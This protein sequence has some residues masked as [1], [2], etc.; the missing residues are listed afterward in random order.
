MP[1]LARGCFSRCIQIGMQSVK[2][3]PLHTILLLATVHVDGNIASNPARIS[4]EFLAGH[5]DHTPTRTRGEP[6]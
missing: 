3:D 5:S 4:L 2:T 6:K 1:H